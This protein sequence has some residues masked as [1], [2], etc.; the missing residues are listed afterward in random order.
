VIRKLHPIAGGVALALILAFWTSTVAAELFGGPAAVVRVK[1]LILWGMIALVP[2]MATVGATGFRMGARATQPLIVAKRRRMPII[3]LNGLL[4]L[5]PSAVLL[6]AR[7]ASGDF[8]AV[9]WSVQAL[10]LVAGALNITLMSLSLRDGLRLAAR[11]PAA[12]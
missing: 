5:L 4:V 6:Q 3:A 1:T 7:A 12:A 10:E 11:R 8:D 2:A 9:F